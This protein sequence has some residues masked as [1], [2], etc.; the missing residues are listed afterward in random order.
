ML[1]RSISNLSTTCEYCDIIDFGHD[2]LLI[3]LMP[4]YVQKV[5]AES[6]KKMATFNGK[7]HE[8]T[9]YIH[10]PLYIR[11]ECNGKYID[12]NYHKEMNS[13]EYV[14][15]KE[16]ILI[17]SKISGGYYVVIVSFDGKYKIEKEEEVY[18]LEKNKDEIVTLKRLADSGHHGKVTHYNYTKNM[19][20]TSDIVY[21]D[22]K[23]QN[24]IDKKLVPYLYIDA[25]KSGDKKL[26]RSYLCDNL[27]NAL[28]DQHLMTF[29][30]D[31]R[32]ID[33]PYLEQYGDNCL[34]LIYNNQNKKQ[35]KIYAF[36]IDDKGRIENITEM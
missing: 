28:D 14:T 33:S 5:C 15:S 27:N 8:I 31:F 29:F 30:G 2:N 1:F 11:I 20:S 32:D 4:F 18:L 34:S 22:N 10:S 6:K 35:G 13:L 24:S 12:I 23:R 3:K 9:Y 36:D 17:Y 19:E 25:I 7:M 16:K 21:M 26:A